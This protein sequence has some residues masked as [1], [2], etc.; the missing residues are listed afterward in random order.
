MTPARAEPPTLADARSDLE[1]FD[2]ALG[3]VDVP[4]HVL[5]RAARRRCATAS[6][7]STPT[8]LRQARHRRAPRRARA[9]SCY[10]VAVDIGTSK[11]IAYLFDLRARRAHRPGG[12]RE[13][14]DA[15][16]RGR[17][18]PHRPRLRQHDETRSR[19]RRP[20]ARASTP[21]SRRST[22]ARR[23]HANHVYDMTVV[24]NT[25]MHH[26]A[27]GLS[28]RGPRRRRRSRRPRPS[29]SRCAASEL[30]IDMNP[31]GGVHF[32]PPI[33]GF[34]G[35]DALAVI[36]ATHLAGKKQAD[37]WPST[38]APT[39]RSRSPTTAAS[40]SPAAPPARRSRATR[41]ATA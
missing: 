3:G 23:S 18:Q 24:G 25:A 15:L 6:G 34:V 38:S 9:P 8:L 4:L 10:G 29:R 30:G 2:E 39:P 14:A 7:R 22:S 26:L 31:D 28:P 32:P 37:A 21:T 11:V 13:P 12:H 16:R 41:S 20:C 1:R 35:S 36:A 40:P 19:W 33:A 5:Q 17:H 27:L